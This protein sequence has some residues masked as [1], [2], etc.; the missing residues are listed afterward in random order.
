MKRWGV[1]FLVLALVMS[2]TSL[3]YAD[4]GDQMSDVDGDGMVE[5]M[6][7]TYNFELESDF[8]GELVNFVFYWGFDESALDEGGCPPPSEEGD[9][10]LAGEG[11]SVEPPPVCL[12]L[13]KDN[14]GQFVSAFV[15]WLKDAEFD[16]PRGRLVKKA[17]HDDFGK[18]PKDKM[19]GDDEGTE[20]GPDHAYGKDKPKKNE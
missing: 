3:A 18:G 16:G 20:G 15:H 10:S 13:K 5:I 6:P 11:D 7:G 17:A 2:I 14:H 9:V 19:Q 8:L 1:I 12:E 4:D